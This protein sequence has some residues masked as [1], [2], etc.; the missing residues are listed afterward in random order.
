MH[1]VSSFK[2]RL[3]TKR[4]EDIETTFIQ[5][6]LTSGELVTRFIYSKTNFSPAR[7]RPKPNAFD[8]SPYDKL[9]VAHCTGLLDHA[10]WGIGERTLG[11]QPGRSTIYGRADVPVGAL[12][13]NKLRAIRDDDPFERH[14]SVVGWPRFDD[15]DEQKRRWKQICLELSE[16][17][18]VKL[19][20]PLTPIRRSADSVQ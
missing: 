16:N 8:P 7:G 17:P 20:T 4:A 2:T 3:Q 14:T 9:S 10:V 6:E 1:W 5:Y 11:N 19:V 12:N 15:G 18:D 13:E